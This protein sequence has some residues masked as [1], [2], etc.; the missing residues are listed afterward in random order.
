MITCLRVAAS[1][2]I[3]PRPERDVSPLV[4]RDR[5]PQDMRP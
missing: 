3:A 5:A 2:V 4:S 1:S